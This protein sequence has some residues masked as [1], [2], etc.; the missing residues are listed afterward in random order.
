DDLFG[1]SLLL[2]VYRADQAMRYPAESGSARQDPEI[3][4]I[5]GLW[6]QS[7]VTSAKRGV[8]ASYARPDAFG[9]EG[10]EVRGG[11]D[12]VEDPT[13]QRLALTQRVW[14]PPMEYNSTAP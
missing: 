12:R 1:G 7:D 8:R 4:P 10:L 5:G 2:D 3:A 11:V 6:A 13:D 14:V 9:I